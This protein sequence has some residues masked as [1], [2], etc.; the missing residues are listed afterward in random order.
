MRFLLHLTAATLLVAIGT[1]GTTS[2]RAA[3]RESRAVVIGRQ[4]IL[5]ELS[6][7]LAKGHLT[8]MEQYRILLHA[9]EVLNADDLHGLEQT[10]DRIATRQ[11]TLRPAKAAVRNKASVQQ[12]TDSDEPGTITPSKYEEPNAA[13]M[14]VG[15]PMRKKAKALSDGPFVEEIP[16]GIGKLASQLDS[17]D[18]EGFGCDLNEC[19]PRRRRWLNVDFIS[20]VDAFKGPVDI[21]NSNG[22]FG[23]RLGVN[24]AVPI[25]PRMGVALQ[26]GT[27]V[28][29]SNLKGSNLPEFNSKIRDQVFATVGMFQRVNGEE[30]AFT[31]GFAYDWLFDDYYSN[32]HFGQWRVK[33]SYEPDSCNEFGV[34]A[35][36]SDHGSTGS[37]P[38]PDGSADVL[39]FKPITQGYLYWKHTWSND[40]SLTGRFGMA[41]QPGEFVFGTES[42]VPLTKNLALTSNFSY[43]MPI[44]GGGPNASLELSGQAQEIWNVSVGI[45]IVLGGFHGC[46][47]RFQPF[48]PVADNGS[49][50][51]RTSS[52]D[53]VPPPN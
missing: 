8:R 15:E 32:F 40:A 27:S 5:D 37:I 44:A 17:N 12:N 9:K 47:A 35:S 48:L 19:N 20:S 38:Y 3:D 28:V 2:A 50:A 16:S 22:N 52:E 14:P 36:L 46:A 11:A 18:S 33:A 42:R 29:L 26:A 49:L 4:Q 39:G 7:A 51:V 1:G 25:L 31:W 34:Q 41:E 23:T 13:E 45:E 30:G 53:L 21:A 43:I 10:L 24:A 6:A